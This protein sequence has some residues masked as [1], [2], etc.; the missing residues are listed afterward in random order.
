MITRWRSR[1]GQTTEY[2]Q[3]VI[4]KLFEA[5]GILLKQLINVDFCTVRI[6]V[7]LQLFPRSFL[8]QFWLRFHFHFLAARRTTRLIVREFSNACHSA[9]LAIANCVDIRHTIYVIL[10]ALFSLRRRPTERSRTA[11]RD[12]ERERHRLSAMRHTYIFDRYFSKFM[13]IQF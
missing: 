4:P 8:A 12:W 11:A 13:K 6:V 5:A 9:R 2:A 1:E 7:I 3:N 10:L